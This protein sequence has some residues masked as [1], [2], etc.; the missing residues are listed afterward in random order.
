MVKNYGVVNANPGRS[1][2]EA[3]NGN[4]TG[5]YDYFAVHSL[6]FLGKVCSGH[7]LAF[8]NLLD[9]RWHKMKNKCQSIVWWWETVLATAIVLFYMLSCIFRFTVSTEIITSFLALFT[10]YKGA[11]TANYI[12][13]KKALNGKTEEEKE[14]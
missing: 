3:C 11:N 8:N 10:V 5:N 13:K 7:S 2:N 6:R 14:E 12:A 4:R 9:S 1:K